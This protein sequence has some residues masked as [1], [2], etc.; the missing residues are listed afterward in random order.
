[1]SKASDFIGEVADAMSARGI[2][3][4]VIDV[5]RRRW[6]TLRPGEMFPCPFCALAARTGY[7]EP[8]KVSHGDQYLRCT[9]SSCRTEIPVGSA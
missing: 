8:G 6:E 1:M 2:P 5:F 3:K 9:N 7:L 4:S